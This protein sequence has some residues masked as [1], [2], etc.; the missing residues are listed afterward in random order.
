MQLQCL[1]GN[2]L[3]EISGF[4]PQASDFADIGLPNNIA[5]QAL[6]ASLHEIL[7]PFVPQGQASR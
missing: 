7:R 5:G 1:F 3:F 2:H 6:L 4:T